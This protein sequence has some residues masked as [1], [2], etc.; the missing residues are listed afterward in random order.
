MHGD[1]GS[2]AAGVIY[3]AWSDSGAGI[4]RG[5]RRAESRLDRAE[6]V[7]F[8]TAD[9]GPWAQARKHWAEIAGVCPDL[10]RAQAMIVLPPNVTATPALAPLPERLPRPGTKLAALVEMLCRPDGIAMTEMI[11]KF[12]WKRVTCSTAISGDLFHKFGIRSKRGPDG[13]YRLVKAA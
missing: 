12:G 13:R 4:V 11:E 7:R 6:A 5:T 3:Q 10:L 2:L 8:L 9:H 1:L